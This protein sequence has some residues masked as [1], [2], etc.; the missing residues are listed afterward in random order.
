MI[1][2]VNSYL[3]L[4]PLLPVFLSHGSS[5]HGAL[6]TPKLTQKLTTPA[7]PNTPNQLI[8]P[9]IHYD[10]QIIEG[11][12]IRA[13]HYGPWRQPVGSAPDKG[14]N[15]VIAGH[16]F[17]YTNPHGTFYYLN[18]VRV[19]DSVGVIWNNKT[20]HYTVASTSV[21]SPDDTSVIAPT[22]TSQLTLYTCTPL[23]LPKNRLVVVAT[24]E[25]V[26]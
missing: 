11:S 12:T 7:P 15:T 24:L 5:G 21:V 3:I 26:S 18:N 4:M 1:I 9:S 13:L 25:S 19:G 6:S 8:I 10:E 17:T 14:S 22:A 2:L 20:Y 16:R 23:W